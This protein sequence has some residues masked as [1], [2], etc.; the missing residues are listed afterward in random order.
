MKPQVITP[1]PQNNNNKESQVLNLCYFQFLYYHSFWT[2]LVIIRLKCEAI[3][4]SCFII[5]VYSY[6]CSSNRYKYCKQESKLKDLKK[7]EA[8]YSKM[9][10]KP[11]LFT[12]L[13][14]VVLT[15]NFMVK[16]LIKRN[17]Q[18]KYFK[19]PY[20]HYTALPV[21]SSVVFKSLYDL[22]SVFLSLTL[23]KYASHKANGA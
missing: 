23:W 8:F 7:C 4:K 21:L 22:I 5:E 15:I 10:S 1:V 6:P 14:H 11:A 16:K 20:K 12:D 17:I 19:F 9:C 3:L 2:T 18:N 13:V